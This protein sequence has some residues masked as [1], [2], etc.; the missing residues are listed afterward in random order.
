[1]PQ[2]SWFSIF[3][4]N[5]DAKLRM[6][7]FSYAGGG[8]T[9]FRRWF[10]RLPSWVEIVAI[11]LPGRE[12]RLQDEIYTQMDTLINA[13]QEVFLDYL[14]KPFVFFGHS[15]GALV[16][17]NLAHSLSHANKKMPLQLFISSFKAPHRSSTTDNYHLLSDELLIQKLDL[18]NGTPRWLL[19]DPNAMKLF[20]PTFRADLKV[21]ET[22]LFNEKK[23]LDIPFHVFGG[24]N[25]LLVDQKELQ[26]WKQHTKS[27]FSLQLFSGGHFYLHSKSRVPLLAQI[28]THLH[29]IIK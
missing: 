27:D 4:P 12:E 17:F 11:R 5:P 18:L 15:M 21:C 24:D 25:D 26:F 14:D 7:C 28:S 6:F 8:T 20:L 9:T 19:N 3:R 23:P 13:L 22:Y 10:H 1:M 29:D 2:N 16:S